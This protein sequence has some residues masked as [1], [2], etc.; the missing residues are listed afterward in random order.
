MAFTNGEGPTAGAWPLGQDARGV[1]QGNPVQDVGWQAP[2]EVERQLYEA[3]LRDNW[4]GYFDVL[5]RT[6]LYFI[7]SRSW[8]DAHPGRVHF[9]PYWNPQLQAKCLALYT[10]GMLPAPDGGDLV[11][12]SNYLEWFA[13]VWPESRGQWIAV[14][15]GSPCE[16]YFPTTPEHRALWQRHTAPVEGSP[17][18]QRALRALSV[19]GPLQG[20]VAF[21]LACGAPL[22]VNNRELWNA[23]AYHGT[24]YSD[25]RKSLARWWGITDR[26]G[27]QDAQHRLLNA[28][29]VSS[30]WEFA[31][32]VRRSLALDFA[33]PV[34]VD[35]WKQVAG[36]AIRQKAEARA[37]EVRVSPEGV[38][39]ADPVDETEVAAQVAGV[40]RLIGRIARYEARFR[41]D[42][43]LAE[44]RFVR[45]V[46][47][48]DYG[49]ASCM[50]RWGLAARYG[51]LEEA[52]QAVVRAGRMVAANYR[53]WE[54]FAA[55]FILGRCLHFDDEDFGKWYEEMVTVHRILTTDPAS[56]WLNI[57]WK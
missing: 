47:A 28:D 31:L 36:R 52:E 44:G 33:G 35:Y 11:F 29:M 10:E 45:T 26:A 30:V 17:D 34:E 53:S 27:W 51:T 12:S 56:P 16:A 5:A 42:G 18:R 50:A 48:W 54:D 3:K 43:L 7:E 55:S 2:S 9:S 19:G 20:P 57:P 8:K 1:L 15:P 23:M 37:A 32:G 21:G 41:A 39:K 49:R 14:N 46:E 40:Q 24:G 25:E 13:E 4:A 6:Y 38:T 22:M